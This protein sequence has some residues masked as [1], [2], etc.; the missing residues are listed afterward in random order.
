MKKHSRGQFGKPKAIAI[1]QAARQSIG[2]VSPS[3]SLELRQ[4]LK[5][6]A[7][8]QQD[9]DEVEA[10]IKEMVDS[11]HSPILDIPGIGYT[12]G[13]MILAEVGDFNR[14]ANADKLLAFSG[15][16]HSKYESGEFK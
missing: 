7:Y 13:A 3:K 12:M 14:F 10:Q 9:L 11:L 16:S 8:V 6:V 4:T 2:K 15:M 1:Q 5:K